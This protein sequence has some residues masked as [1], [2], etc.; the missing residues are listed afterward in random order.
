MTRKHIPPFETDITALGKGGVG[1]GTAPDGRPVQVKLA[2]P[3]ARVLVLPQGFQKGIWQG[4]R[5]EMITPPP[6]AQAPRCATFGLC[7]G[8]AL[9]EIPYEAQVAARHAHALHSVG[10]IEATIHPP[11]LGS[12]PWGYRNKVEL[13][14][15]S[16]RYLSEAEHAAGLP[17]DGRFL[18]FH[19][20]GR[21]DRVVDTEACAI[22]STS[23]N[24]VLEI[25]R[26]HSLTED[27]PPCWN[28]RKHEG[29]W[30]HLAIRRAVA[31]GELLVAIDTA[32]GLETALSA[33]AEALL[34]AALPE[35]ERVVG[36]QWLLN[37]GVAD[38]ARGTLQRTWGRPYIVERLGETG[39][40]LSSGSFFQSS[41]RGA[42]ALYDTVSQAL[43]PR[44]GHLLDLYS[45]IGTISLYLAEGYAQI[46]G[47]EEV[48]DAVNDAQANAALNGVQATY[49]LG[50]VE[51]H[52]GV[53]A[54]PV[55]AIVVDPPRAGLHPAVAAALA[56]V[57]AKTLIYV[58]CNPASLARD[59]PLLAAGGWRAT[60]LWTVDLFP[61]T[62]HME[63]VLRLVKD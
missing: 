21:W 37:E 26:A 42:A 6:A 16:A 53:L 12:E 27:A 5:L 22:I 59:L 23:M 28:P 39:F 55:D 32:A 24:A 8:C 60:D 62:G 13:S 45:G 56:K 11:V 38:V 51:A 54:T 40:H 2:P 47:I 15:G 44:G 63:A 61:Q 49:I 43:G 48:P 25:A 34:A 4:K 58:A 46:T 50:K 41:T 30:R 14:W 31:T 52:L 19:A 9:Q 20:P 3:G 57:V 35:G 1:M 36:V 29:F 33:L 17:I 10:P 18:G 7:G